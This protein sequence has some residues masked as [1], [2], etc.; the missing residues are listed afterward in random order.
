M[1]P[2]AF[3]RR[4][5]SAHRSN[6]QCGSTVGYGYD[7]IFEDARPEPFANHADDALAATLKAHRAARI[8]AELVVNRWNRRLAGGRADERLFV[9]VVTLT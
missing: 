5:R 9:R 6:T 7:P 2:R 3:W 4:Q 8:E 1:S